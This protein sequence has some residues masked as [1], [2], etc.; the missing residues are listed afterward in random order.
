[1]NRLQKDT[2]EFLLEHKGEWLTFAKDRDTIESVCALHNLGIVEVSKGR[3]TLK[4]KEK[5]NRFLASSD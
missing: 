4:S 3:V 5:A 2:I 1:M